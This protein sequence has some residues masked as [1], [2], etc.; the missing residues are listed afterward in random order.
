MGSTRLPKKAMLDFYGEPMIGFICKRLSKLFNNR[1]VIAT[2]DKRENDILELFA[3]RHH[4]KIIRGSEEDLYSR[5]ALVLKK[6]NSDYF[7]RVNGDCPLVDAEFIAHFEHYISEY[8]VV[9]NI[10][11]RSFPYGISV[12]IIRSEAF[13]KA[14]K[15][16]TELHREH[17]TSVFYENS[18]DFNIFNILNSKKHNTEKEIK[19]FV[20]DEICDYEKIRKLLDNVNDKVNYKPE[21]LYSFE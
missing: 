12:E 3:E 11:K 16:L 19:K 13:R 20:I 1:I 14:E 21:N 6:Y 18:D 2:S 9:T 5:T 15:F 4:Y 7:I 10:F 8:D 17:L